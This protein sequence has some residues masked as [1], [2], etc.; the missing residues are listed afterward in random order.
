[1]GKKF[2]LLY[3]FLLALLLT[4]IPI[5]H[6]QAPVCAWRGY[7][8]I[9]IS[10]TLVDGNT[11][12]V[13]TSYTNG[14]QATTGTIE[15]SSYYMI[16]IPGINGDSITLQI[17]GV[18]VTQGFRTWSCDDPG[19][20]ILNISINTSANGASCTYACGCSGG[21]CNSGVCSSTPS[22]TTTTSPGGGGGGGTTTTVA[23]T[24]IVTTTAMAT[25]TTL[26]P[27]V[28]TETISSITSGKTGTV[29]FTN[30][31]VTDISIK[32]KNAV[33]NVQVTVTKTDS[34]PSTVAIAASGQAYAYLNIEKTNIKDS[35][36]S[37]VK[38]KFKVEKS[39]INA[40]NINPNPIALQRYSG[41]SWNKLTTSKINEDANY[42]Y[43]E[44]ES[45]GLS[46]FAV[47]GEKII[48]TTTPSPTKTTTTVKT[49]PPGKLE[50]PGLPTTQVI[51][52]VVGV[53]AVLALVVFILVRV[54][55][56]KTTEI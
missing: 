51:G 56:A 54:Q 40:N 6:S 15:S 43:F 39:W 23:A 53:I 34:K 24:T 50:T 1:M 9:N 2:I 8:K 21:Y 38:I 31:P 30:V 55:V 29:S 47:A 25:T 42:I 44:V 4:S 11:S 36:I 33:N 12:H 35:D 17:C 52:I 10:G 3:S 28:E 16:N 37:Q 48:T 14:A 41:G 49:R 13:L 7:T 27:V 20:H 5:A 45:P 46:V 19:Y 32:V 26:P 22:T 18:N